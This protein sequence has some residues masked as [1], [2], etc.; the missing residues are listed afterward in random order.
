MVVDI[1][2]CATGLR[3]FGPYLPHYSCTKTPWT[4]RVKIHDHVKAMA[5]VLVRMSV[6]LRTM[7]MRRT[8]RR[9]RIVDMIK[10]LD[11][12]STTLKGLIS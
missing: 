10:D 8:L 9:Q 3:T 4:Y 12:C 5:D 11:R 2:I 1:A 6:D 7:R